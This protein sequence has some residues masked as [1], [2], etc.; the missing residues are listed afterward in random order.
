MATTQ[1]DAVGSHRAVRQGERSDHDFS[2]WVAQ[3]VWRALIP[4]DERCITACEN[5]KVAPK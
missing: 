1:L 2:A 4:P 5:R 3:G